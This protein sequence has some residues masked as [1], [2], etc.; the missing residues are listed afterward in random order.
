ME[1]GKFDFFLRPKASH[2]GQRET[3]RFAR[4]TVVKYVTS[5]LLQRPDPIHITKHALSIPF[6]M[7]A[8][9]QYI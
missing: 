7:H 5:K 9:I 3:R 6:D 8:Y 4:V 1:G 2:N